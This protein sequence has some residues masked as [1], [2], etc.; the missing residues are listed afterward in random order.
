MSISGAVTLRRVSQND[1]RSQT[2]EPL[3]GNR[4]WYTL[5]MPGQQPDLHR[6]KFM[7]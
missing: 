1:V 3:C 4:G 2:Y 5:L 7:G 6:V